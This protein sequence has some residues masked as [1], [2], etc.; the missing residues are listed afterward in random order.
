MQQLAFAFVPMVG[1]LVVV[2][3]SLI[4]LLFS[5]VYLPA[6][7]VFRVAALS[8]LLAALPLDGVMRARAQ[9]RYML[10]LSAAK[11]AATALLVLSGLAF[12]GPIG[13]LAGWIAAE[14]L[15]RAA[16]LR[17]AATLFDVPVRRILPVR[18]LARQPARAQGPPVRRA[19]RA[20]FAFAAALALAT[21]LRLPAAWESGNALSHVSGAWMTLADDLARGTFYRPMYDPALGYGGTRFFPLAFSLHAG[22]FRAGVPLLAGGYALS[23][24]AAVL[25][26]A[27]AFALLRGVGLSRAPAAAFAALAHAGFAGQHGLSAVR[28]DLLPAGL[29]AL[30][31][32]AV[33]SP[34]RRLVAAVLLFALAFAAKPTA[35]TAPAAAVLWLALR[36]EGRRALALALGTALPCAGVVAATDALSDGRFAEALRAC[37]AG[38]AGPWDVVR[39]PLRLAHQLAVGDPAGLVLVGAAL[40]S[41]AALAPALVP[42]VRWRAPAPPLLLA[43]LWLAAAGGGVL[44][45]FVSPGTGVNHLVEVEVAAAV[46]L[47][48]VAFAAGCAARLA[49]LLAPAAAAAGLALALATWHDDLGTSRLREARAVGRA[50][51]AGPILSEDPLVPLLAGLR[52]VLLDAWMVRLAASRDPGFARA[53]AE[54]LARGDYAGVVLFRDLDEAGADAWFANGNLGLP[55]VAQIRR[56]YRPGGG[57]GRYHLYLPRPAEPSAAEPPPGASRVTTARDGPRVVTGT[58]PR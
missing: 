38:G 44:V 47:G 49:R 25:V 37:A 52:P 45:V 55:L 53:L 34:R 42:L 6:V 58:P 56:S 13:A 31:L 27:G 50:L 17:R 22:L 26:V 43:L 3:P 23:L 8:V 28:G 54:D 40:A 10:A 5:P 19:E 33:A 35:L 9:N 39:A 30:G 14:A 48:G 36:G 20:F 32:A 2:A 46:A 4:E 16:M 41:A 24:A 18:A 12:A 15:A 11:L 7:P 1:I 57:T 29:S 51:P 21:A